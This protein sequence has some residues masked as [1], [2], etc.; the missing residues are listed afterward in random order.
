MRRYFEK[1]NA[2]KLPPFDSLI[3]SDYEIGSFIAPPKNT[4]ELMQLLVD[5][6]GGEGVDRTLVSLAPSAA[7][8]LYPATPVPTPLP[9]V[10][11]P[12][13]VPTMM[14][15]TRPTMAVTSEGDAETKA[16]GAQGGDPTNV[17]GEKVGAAL[18]GSK[19]SK[20]VEVLWPLYV[21]AAVLF[22]CCGFWC[23][24][25]CMRK[26]K[27]KKKEEING[28]SR[29]KKNKR[30]KRTARSPKNGKSGD[31][32][33][34]CEISPM[35][36]RRELPMMMK[37]ANGMKI[38][39]RR[40]SLK[41]P[42][43]SYSPTAAPSPSGASG[44]VIGE[45]PQR[46]RR[47]GVGSVSKPGKKMQRKKQMSKADKKGKYNVDGEIGNDGLLFM[48]VEQECI[49]SINRIESVKQTST[50]TLHKQQAVAAAAKAE[51]AAASAAALAPHSSAATALNTFG[52]QRATPTRG[53]TARIA[54]SASTQ[55]QFNPGRS[56]PALQ[57]G[58]VYANSQ[59]SGM[60]ARSGMSAAANSEP[61]G[62][63]ALT[64]EL[65]MV[66]LREGRQRQRPPPA[67]A[68]KA[69]P[70]A[71]RRGTQQIY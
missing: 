54:A 56:Q 1:N 35:I 7:P 71:K 8:S 12:T 69:K 68:G 52:R 13:E 22:C 46:D 3:P 64:A 40:G 65:G 41:G 21:L 37:G 29:P 23:R 70:R 34:E 19:D 66:G 53:A 20:L 2:S 62:F 67:S 15:S 61:M 59:Q 44:F 58:G 11:P 6:Y 18:T 30:P 10:S 51:A 55:R 28:R 25:C 47:N 39:V 33:D 63:T 60:S 17:F 50:A 49:R 14:P 31:D 42:S 48:R 27:E 9:T 26:Y 36:E 57:R 43:S 4:S 5:T 24:S 45:E 16:A 32:V 38:G